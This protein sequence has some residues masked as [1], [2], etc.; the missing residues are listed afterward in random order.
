MT[1]VA[2]STDGARLAT[3]GH[4]GQVRIWDV[5]QPAAV[6][7]LPVGTGVAAVAFS[8]DGT[9]LATGGEDRIVRLWDLGQPR[10][11]PLVLAGHGGRVATVAFST[12]GNTLASGS[13]DATVR[14]WSRAGEPGA[15]LLGHAGPV[16]AVA[17][18]PSRDTLAS[19]SS[20]GTARLWFL[21]GPKAADAVRADPEV[22]TAVLSD[23]VCP[24]VGRNLSPQEWSDFVG[25]G[26]AYR[27]TCPD[28][29]L[30]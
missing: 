15:V 22:D 17:F 5:A 2:F 6:A 14:L 11:P 30:P 12:D 3:G 21:D 1:A 4:D 10:V 8:P 28:L 16:T 29:P 20:D 19:A 25:P 18:G 26:V 27:R 13:E 7:T 23:L 9:Q 24:E